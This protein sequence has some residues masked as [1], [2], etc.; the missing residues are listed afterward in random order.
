MADPRPVIRLT[1][2]AG[3]CRRML[4]ELGCGSADELLALIRAAVGPAY[5]VTGDRRL[6]E[7]TEDDARGGR[8]D[9][10]R[11]AGDLQRALADDRVAAVVA[12]R[13]GAWLTR[14]LPRIDFDVLRHR[15]SRVALFGFSELTTVINV[16]ARYP[17]AVCWYDLGPAFISTGLAGWA[18]RQGPKHLRRP[19]AARRWALRR[20]RAELAAFFR[21]ATSLLEGRG[22]VRAVRGRLVA[23]R[24]PGAT[25]VTLAGG[26]LAVLVSLIGTPYAR[27]VFRSGRWLMLEDVNEAPHRLDRMVAHLH[28]AGALERCGGLLLGDFRDGGHDR[29]DAVRSSLRR[30]LPA[31]SSLPVVVSDDFGHTWPM[32]PLPVG[33]PVELRRRGSRIEVVP[34]WAELRVCDPARP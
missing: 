21:D 4:G 5:R 10:L 14:I 30:V 13:G 27:S 20:F 23:G 17:R 11:R 7:A 6:I 2:P 16:A 33:R 3:S 34:P 28:L 31:R 19:A 9:D 24:L 12:L 29:R 15:R 8:S 26:T 32:A 25:R 22:S 18:L 1:A